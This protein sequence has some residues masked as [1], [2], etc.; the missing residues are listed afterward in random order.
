MKLSKIVA[1]VGA[2][3]IFVCFFLPWESLSFMGTKIVYSGY[4]KAAG[5]PPGN[6]KLSVDPSDYGSESDLD[7][8]NEVWGDLLGDTLSDSEIGILSGVTDS[9]N[10]AFAKPIM[11]IFPVWYSDGCTGNSPCISAF[12][13]GK[14]Y[15]CINEP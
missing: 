12:Q 3:L 9:I 7:Y 8:I 10:R 13:P 4:Q 14:K 5:S 11:F 1:I 2:V 15:G 6:Y